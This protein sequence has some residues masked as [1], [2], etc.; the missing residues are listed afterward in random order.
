MSVFRRLHRGSASLPLL[1]ALLVAGMGLALADDYSVG[2]SFT[3]AGFLEHDGVAIN[4]PRAMRFRLYASSS[5]GACQTVT[6]ASVPI[7]A[8]AFSVVID[9]VDDACLAQGQLFL[10]VAVADANTTSYT[11]LGSR[12]EVTSL[13][14][15]SAIDDT[16]GLLVNDGDVVFTDPQSADSRVL[17]TAHDA[18]FSDTG[19][20][21]RPLTSTA[22]GDALF[23]VLSNNGVERLR[24]E[25]DGE[26]ST[27]GD[28]HA[29]GTVSAADVDVTGAYALTHTDVTH[30]VLE[31]TYGHT[32][33]H[34]IRLSGGG[35]TVIGSGESPIAVLDDVLLTGEEHLYLATD[36]QTRFVD[37]N[38]GNATTVAIVDNDGIR[39]SG[40]SNGCPSDME[41]LGDDC[42]D[43]TWTNNNSIDTQ[44]E[45]VNHCHN[46]GKSL[47]TLQ[48]IATCDLIN[49]SNSTSNSC[50]DA[51]DGFDSG[52]GYYEVRTGSYLQSEA[53]ANDSRHLLQTA[54]SYIPGNSPGLTTANKLDYGEGDGD[55]PFFCCARANP[56]AIR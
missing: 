18:A 6:F 8:G 55:M 48:Q 14:F 32:Y 19:V 13:P 10:D 56:L 45:A 39:L 22:S 49:L 5:T 23:R 24:V 41:P 27:T 50:G 52:E 34:D 46:Q 17:L 16:G 40:E 7:E 38:S 12:S 25:H 26:V 44:M 33:G 29:T 4:T 53:L 36:G 1:L 42:I 15:A 9:D 11:L 2:R 28:V 47:C 21:L 37:V 51:T 43:R 31:A 54:I 30:A 3:Y 35:N 20:S